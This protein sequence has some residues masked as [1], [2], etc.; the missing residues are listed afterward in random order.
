VH[1]CIPPFPSLLSRRYGAAY[2][3]ADQA[4]YDPSK[5]TM[6]KLAYYYDIPTPGW[7]V[8]YDLTAKVCM[9][10]GAGMNAGVGVEAF[11]SHTVYRVGCR[12]KGG[13]CNI[14]SMRSTCLLNRQLHR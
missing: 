5:S 12:S 11:A 9:G 4:F 14:W 10:V 6:K 7:A 2:T 1:H 3:G 8:V 13:V